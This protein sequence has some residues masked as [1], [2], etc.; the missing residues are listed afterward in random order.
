ML[1]SGY[2]KHRACFVTLTGNHV[3]PTLRAAYIQFFRYLFHCLPCGLHLA[4]E[5][6]CILGRAGFSVVLCLYLDHLDLNKHTEIFSY[7]GRDTEAQTLHLLSLRPDITFF[8][9]LLSFWE[10][11]VLYIYISGKISLLPSWLY[12]AMSQ[13]I[14]MYYIYL[15]C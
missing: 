14:C 15:C 12:P 13:T 9:Q 5:Q 7:C 3:A 10:H 6:Q 4:P 11:T 1:T 8:I 2:L